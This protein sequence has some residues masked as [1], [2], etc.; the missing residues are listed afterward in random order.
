MLYNS[1]QD[2]SGKHLVT[3][4]TFL[5]NGAVFN[6][7]VSAWDNNDKVNGS[8]TWDKAK[9][10]AGKFSGSGKSDLAVMYNAGQDA[11]GKNMLT[12]YKF[13]GNG[14]TLNAPVDAWD[15]NDKVNG[16]WDW[17]RADLA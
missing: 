6:A 11:S 2:S 13:A 16:S 17:F 12:M 7:P 1:G 5:S 14:S 3:L 4:Y 10:V 9:L 8:W 15:N